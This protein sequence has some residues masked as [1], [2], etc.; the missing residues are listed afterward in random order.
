M[1]FP[2]FKKIKFFYKNPATLSLIIFQ[3][4]LFFLYSERQQEIRYEMSKIL[5]NK[6]FQKMQVTLFSQH[7]LENSQNYSPFI[8]EL[9][10]KDTVKENQKLRFIAS[11]SLRDKTFSTRTSHD[12][13]DKIA[14]NFWKKKSKQL[15]SLQSQ[16][17]LSYWGVTASNN[18]LSSWFSYQF[19]HFSLAHVL[20]NVFFLLLFGVL[21][22]P[23]LGSLFFLG[24]YI[25]AGIFSAFAYVS[26]TGVSL[27][28]L[29]GASGAVSGLM[30]LTCV[31]Y[32]KSNVRYF[33][34]VLPFKNYR[35]F[36]YL[37]LWVGFLMWFISDL[38]GFLSN[39]QGVQS[40]AY[41]A[42]LGGQFFGLIAGLALFHFIKVEVEKKPFAFVETF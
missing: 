37:P 23:L 34:F 21:L 9:A 27:A 38:T 10:A 20:I 2:F 16:S 40:M 36:V 22:E 1:I 24:F 28:P 31:L 8:R 25:L 12:Y 29:V 13:K 33:W 19:I 17:P 39:F 14:F 3:V 41:S 30:A 15:V 35:G 4:L 32:G 18:S 11:L 5:S 6:F 42:H 26:L 7:I